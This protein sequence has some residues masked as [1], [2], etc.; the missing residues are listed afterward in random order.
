[1]DINKDLCNME[2]MITENS[3]NPY[4]IVHGGFIFGLADTAAGILLKMNNI[5]GVTSTANIIYLR[6]VTSDKIVATAKLL[7]IGSKISIVEVEVVALDKLVAKVS[8][9]YCVI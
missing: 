2:A 8:F 6:P 1:M 9:E 4:N 5:K 3:M 7:K